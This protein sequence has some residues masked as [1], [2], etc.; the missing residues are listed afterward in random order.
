MRLLRTRPGTDT[1]VV[2]RGNSVIAGWGNYVI[3]NPSRRGNFLIADK[4]MRD[5]GIKAAVS[6]PVRY[7]IIPGQAAQGFDVLRP[8]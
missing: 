8:R 4:L 3:V 2:P 1:H 5:G 6:V 7:P